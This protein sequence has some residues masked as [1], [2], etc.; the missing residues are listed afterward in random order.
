M[1][2]GTERRFW[3][4]MATERHW[5]GRDVDLKLSRK[6]ALFMSLVPHARAYLTLTRVRIFI[7]IKS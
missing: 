3:E 4:A 6:Q 5:N 1:A 7:S 2:F